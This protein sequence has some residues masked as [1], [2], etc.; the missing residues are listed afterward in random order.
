MNIEKQKL[1]E[2]LKILKKEYMINTIVTYS[3]I[4]RSILLKEKTQKEYFR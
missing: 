4:Y 3:S 1:E 2:E